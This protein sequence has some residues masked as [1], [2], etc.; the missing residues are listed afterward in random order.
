MSRAA[1]CTSIAPGSSPRPRGQAEALRVGRPTEAIRDAVWADVRQ[2]FR[3]EFLNRIHETVV[4]HEFA[5]LILQGRFGPKDV[6][7]VNVE[8]G[9]FAFERVVH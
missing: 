6:I 3:P 9:E 8:R 7:P 1:T 4:F 2:H 5:R